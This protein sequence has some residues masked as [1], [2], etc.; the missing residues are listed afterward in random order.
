MQTL[1]R[2]SSAVS[3]LETQAGL[4]VTAISDLRAAVAAGGN[5]AQLDALS[6]RIEGATASLQAAVNPPADP[7]PAVQAS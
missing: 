2:L 3:G 5:S 6:S 1:D 4:T 7:A